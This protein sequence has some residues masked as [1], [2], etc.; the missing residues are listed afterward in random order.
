M[1]IQAVHD[2]GHAEF[3]DA[4][5]NVATLAVFRRKSTLG[6]ELRVV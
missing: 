5:M 1:D 3:T 2:A 4:E 6:V